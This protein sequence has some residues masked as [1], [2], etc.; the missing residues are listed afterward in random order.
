[1]LQQQV[2]ASDKINF[3]EAIGQRSPNGCDKR[4]N[5][6]IGTRIPPFLL[7]SPATSNTTSTG[8]NDGASAGNEDD[9][10]YKVF[11]QTSAETQEGRGVIK[12][13]ML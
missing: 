12:I 10:D 4:Q 9:P 6:F 8:A 13:K 3:Q 5:S 1:M 2:A 11:L 7:V